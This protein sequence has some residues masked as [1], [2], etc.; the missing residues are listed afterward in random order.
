[1]DPTGREAGD[2][3]K[4]SN[5]HQNVVPVYTVHTYTTVCIIHTQDVQVTVIIW[6]VQFLGGKR[7]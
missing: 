5:H 4:I 6:G 3:T 2:P 7:R 1:M